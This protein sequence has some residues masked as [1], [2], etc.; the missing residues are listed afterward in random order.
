MW[1]WIKKKIRD[2][3][4]NDVHCWFLATRIPTLIIKQ[5]TP[6]HINASLPGAP[7]HIEGSAKQKPRRVFNLTL[8]PFILVKHSFSWFITFI[9]YIEIRGQ[10]WTSS[11]GWFL[12]L[13][14]IETLL[15]FSYAHRTL[16]KEREIE[17]F[18]TFRLEKQ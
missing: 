8:K 1:S 2:V 18:T 3:H 17:I 16:I 11:T 10:Q 15:S 14:F 12:P 5:G 6:Q 9:G 13:C 4:V 7:H